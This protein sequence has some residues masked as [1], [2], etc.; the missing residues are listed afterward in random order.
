MKNF[1][2]IKNTKNEETAT[3]TELAVFLIKHIENPCEDLDG[4]NIRDFY[5]REA[6]K[7]MDKFKNP[8]AKQLLQSV[9]EKYF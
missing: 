7:A 9:V 1:E 6:K 8:E 3:D 5:I 4:N 2:K